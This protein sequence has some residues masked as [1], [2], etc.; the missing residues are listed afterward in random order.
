[1]NLDYIA[2]HYNVPAKLGQRIRYTGDSRGP[3]DGTIKGARNAHLIV[4]FDHA[5]KDSILHPTW[6][7]EYLPEEPASSSPLRLLELRV[8]PAANP[9]SIVF[10]QDG[11]VVGKIIDVKPE[12]P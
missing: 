2:E 11:K 10:E 6:E 12:A 3:K 8:D 9:S 5:P 1:M 7:V 4:R